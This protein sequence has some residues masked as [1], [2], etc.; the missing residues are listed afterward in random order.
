MFQKNCNWNVSFYHNFFQKWVRHVRDKDISSFACN[1]LTSRI[2]LLHKSNSSREKLG[3]H[4][5]NKHQS[6]SGQ[7][8]NDFCLN[9]ICYYLVDVFQVV[10]VPGGKEEDVVKSTCGGTKIIFNKNWDH[11]KSC[12]KR[13]WNS[14]RTSVLTFWT[15]FRN[16]E[17]KDFNS[18]LWIQFWFQKWGI[19]IYAQTSELKIDFRFLNLKLQVY[20][21]VF[22][23]MYILLYSDTSVQKSDSNWEQV[24][25][26]KLSPVFGFRL[27]NIIISKS[28]CLKRYSFNLR[29]F[30]K[31][32]TQ[33]LACCTFLI[34]NHDF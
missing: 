34:Q 16:S 28:D 7:R 19:K 22:K 18:E 2:R 4:G 17:L 31:Y 24:L 9:C 30:L 15:S 33:D 5:E 20:E 10:I 23:V 21:F 12:S 29:H 27:Q 3:Q 1:N 14:V 32:S 6:P 13:D 11:R 8:Y 25:E 26:L